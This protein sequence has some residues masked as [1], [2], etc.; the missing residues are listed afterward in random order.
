MEGQ[1]INDYQP[2]IN[3]NPLVGSGAENSDLEI[4]HFFKNC[5]S[6]WNCKKNI[7]EH[8]GG[9]YIAYVVKIGC[10]YVYMTSLPLQ[11]G[12][13]KKISSWSEFLKALPIIQK[14]NCI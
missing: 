8:T 14:N 11:S 6:Q 3:K 5:H 1:I 13:V 9:T 10:L 7:L 2:E 4:P 12:V